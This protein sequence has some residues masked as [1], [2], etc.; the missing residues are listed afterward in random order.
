M[1]FGS[2]P[3]LVAR[4]LSDIGVINIFGA[5]LNTV[6]AWS[7]VFILIIICVLAYIRSKTRFGRAVRAVEDDLE[8]AELVGIPKEKI[9]LQIFFI[10]GALAGLAGIIEGLDVGIIPASGLIYIL[11]TIVAAVIG[12]MRSFWGGIIGAF[13]L[14]T[15]QQ[16]TI[17]FFGGSW[18]QAVP[19]VIL[20]IMLWIRPHGI[21]KR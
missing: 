16:L 14:A 20:I 8:V 11:P 4:N 12:G 13:I 17:V 18:V 21:L 15:T 2:Q 10:S 7:I 19:F 5:T 9:L 1:I 6:E 3:I